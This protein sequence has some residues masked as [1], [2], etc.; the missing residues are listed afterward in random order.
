MDKTRFTLG[1]FS[2]PVLF[3]NQLYY[4]HHLGSTLAVASS[5]T[6][7]LLLLRIALAR[8]SNCLWPKLKLL[9]PSDTTKSKLEMFSFSST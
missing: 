1:K 7:I 4:L 9:P 8:H 3:C 6:N 2:F 5:K